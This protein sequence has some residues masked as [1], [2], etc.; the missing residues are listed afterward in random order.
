MSARSLPQLLRSGAYDR[1]WIRPDVVAGV[2]VAAMLV[3]QAMAYAEL[4]G[5]PPSAGF[6][7]ALVALP[8]YALLGTS[9]HLG[10]G[11]EPGT[12]I[13]AAAAAA[14]L[15]GGDV[16][17]YA[18]L[19]A[20]IGALVGVIALLAGLLRIGFVADLLSKP[21][22]VGYI[23]GV[24]VTLLTSQ[25]RA[26]TGV[27]IDADNPFERVGQFIT[28]LDQI[29]GTTVAVGGATLAIILVFRRIRP[30]W[31]GALI[32]LG[33]S[34]VT[35]ALL[36]L[37][38]GVVGEIEAAL[39]TPDFPD[40]EWSDVTSLLPAALGVALIGYT[41]NIL[42][43]RSIATKHGYTVDADRELVALGAVNV[44]GGF[45]GG[46]PMSS[47]ASRS[48]VPSTIG[49]RSQLS[50]LIT[51]VAV[52]TALIA[53]R[54]LLAEIPRAGLAAVI[55]AAAIA[56]VDIDGFRRLAQLSRSET[57]LAGMTCVAVIGIDLLTGVLV[58]VGLS[59]LLALARM[60]RPH[61]SI[62]GDGEGLDGWIDLDDERA[63]PLSGLL[64]YRFDAPLFFANGEFFVERVRRALEQN[65]G[66]ETGVVLD[67]EG[68]G[69]IDTTAVDHLTT[70]F[71]ELSAESVTVS[72]ARA[73]PRVLAALDRAG[74]SA[75]LGEGRV[76]PTINAA[77]ADHRAREQQ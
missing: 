8:I 52:V 2:T 4:G 12:A 43:A 33:A 75:R 65:P 56:V 41:D 67:M 1:S 58:A 47:S 61:D 28:R 6:R 24:G 32:G 39:P 5:L 31:P 48:F 14:S 10:I 74:L 76:F 62:L 50:S 44:A 64:V 49:S 19:M 26:F 42:T 20:T 46:F 27:S 36:D 77:V 71:D 70:L 53:G 54:S 22:L 15:A 18:A 55:V 7:A 66:D 51:L 38:V 9:R 35:V 69:S 73:N 45:V 68:V 11:P 16:D 57:L 3:P 17:R 40:V 13:L 59:I 30:T 29:D 34:V 63:K 60:A 72:V 25:L 23:T 37:N 21:V